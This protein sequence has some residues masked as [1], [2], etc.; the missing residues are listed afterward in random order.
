[1]TAPLT[2]NDAT[3]FTRAVLWDGQRSTLTI[4]TQQGGG[5]FAFM[6]REDWSSRW[7]RHVGERT[8][9]ATM[10]PTRFPTAQAAFDAAMATPQI[11]EAP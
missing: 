11:T 4:S 10:S 6:H 1:M 9:W 3:Q 5:W 2:L 8:F 7:L